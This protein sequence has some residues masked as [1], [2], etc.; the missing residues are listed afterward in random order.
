MIRFPGHWVEAW[1]N[2]GTRRPRSPLRSRRHFLVPRLEQL[3]GRTLLSAGDLDPI[4]GTG[5]KV[6]M[7]FQGPVSATALAMAAQPDGKIVVAGTDPAVDILLARY[8]P[9]GSLDP[10]FGSAG[11]AST[12]SFHSAVQRLALQADGKLVVFGSSSGGFAVERYNPDGSLDTAF[13]LGGRVLTSFA[14]YVTG[15]DGA[16]EPDGK[17]IEVGT[18]FTGGP[19]GIYEVFMTRYNPDGSLDHSFGTNGTVTHGIDA[20]TATVSIQTDSRIVVASGKILLRFNPDGQLDPSFGQG[21]TVNTDLTSGPVVVQPDGKLLALE[22]SGT[23]V[24]ERFNTNGSLDTG[25]GSAGKVFIVNV[26][27]LGGPNEGLAPLAL[28]QDGKV[29][30]SGD[31]FINSQMVLA[32]ARFSADGSPD[33][34]FGTN[35]QVNTTFPRNFGQ[36]PALALEPDQKIVA[37]LSPFGVARLNPDGSIDTG[38]GTNGSVMTA[39][40][41]GTLFSSANEV[42]VQPDGKLLAGGT[43]GSNAVLIRYNPDGTLDPSFGTAGMITVPSNQGFALQKDG[44]I[45]VAGTLLQRYNGDGSPDPTFATE[46]LSSP[47]KPIV[48]PDDKVLI[49]LQRFN[50]DGSLDFNFGIGGTAVD[51]TFAAGGI[52]VQPDGKVVAVGTGRYIPHV[53]VRFN[54]NGSLDPTF[55]SGGEVK[56]AVTANALTIQSDGK[57]VLGSSSL[58]ERINPD[59]SLDTTFGVDGQVSYNPNASTSVQVALALLPDTRIVVWV[60]AN[61]TQLVVFRPNGNPDFTVG[62]GAQITTDL[63]LAS[64]SVQADDK[65]VLAGNAN[66]TNGLTSFAVERYLMTGPSKLSPNHRFVS[67][68]YVDLLGRNADPSGLALWSGL[69]DQGQSR[70]QVIQGIQSSL[71]YRTRI[72]KNLYQLVLHRDPD[73]GGMTTWVDFLGNGGTAE[74]LEAMLLGSDEFFAAHNNDLNAGFLPALY[75]IALHR[76]ID[77]AGAQDW[78]QALQSGK[79]TRSAVAAAVLAS[80]ESDQLEV[81]MLYHHLLHRNADPGGLNSFVS[82]LEGGMSQEQ[83]TGLLLTSPEYGSQ[84]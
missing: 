46:Y 32:L 5:G 28:Q 25:F 72:V 8:N 84:I 7:N 50:P 77:A 49:G 15:D 53:L 79:L 57:I 27:R 19:Q 60:V 41:I 35:G 34:T 2:A 81:Q 1:K 22:G 16:V 74:N 71:E 4:L 20:L 63:S 66:D 51:P 17:I 52:A 10:S 68:V 56:L 80:V 39:G 42:V 58:L 75:Q 3:E 30:V 21:G 62:A 24:L 73:N 29:I 82:L 83:V 54:T 36:P 40:F 45:I 43:E 23:L 61:P 69:L 48:A 13:G 55:G 6:V 31:N 65:V 78:S 64:I 11:R 44:R 37:L 76:P 70:L 26:G 67:Q 14:V 33:P 12:T 18:G 59:G 38:F 47:Q 9:D